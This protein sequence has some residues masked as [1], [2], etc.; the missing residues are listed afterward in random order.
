MSLD[1]P[2]SNPVVPEPCECG[3]E[4]RLVKKFSGWF[5]VQCSVCDTSGPIRELAAEAVEDWNE[6]RTPVK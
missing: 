1:L 2:E 3:G 6:E 5:Q 4:A